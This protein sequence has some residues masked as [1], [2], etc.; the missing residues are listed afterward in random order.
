VLRD[1]DGS[2]EV[3]SPPMSVR[4]LAGRQR[5]RRLQV[6]GGG[7]RPTGS[8]VRGAVFDMLAHR[9]WL[10]G[11]VVVDLFAGS[12]ALG[13]EAL[14]R[15]AASAVFIDESPAA[16]RV[17]RRNLAV[18]GMADRARVLALPVERGLRRLGAEGFVA[19][20]VL[21]DP[22]YGRGLARRAVALVAAS[23]VLLV[24]G[25]MAVEHATGEEMAVPDEFA[26]E[27]SRRHGRTSVTLLVR[28]GET[29]SCPE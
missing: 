14:S 25:W 24:G 16:A 23:R 11:R 15:G 29:T 1:R 20:G 22:P 5:G 8:L 26:L 17:V 2:E 10:A 7:T 9:E 21:A 13:I 18:S 12:G 3:T 6:P 19:T 4:V 27:A 28:Q